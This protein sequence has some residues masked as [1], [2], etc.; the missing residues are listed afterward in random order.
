MYLA[1]GVSLASEYASSAPTPSSTCPT[2]PRSCGGLSKAWH[3]SLVWEEV[4]PVEKDKI[5]RN[6]FYLF[7]H[8]KE[9]GKALK[10]ITK[11]HT[12]KQK[13]ETEFQKRTVSLVHKA[14]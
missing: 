3:T 9:T 2:C 11:H 5:L 1:K 6:F 14:A 10:K 8:K 4:V 7:S 12:E 13:V